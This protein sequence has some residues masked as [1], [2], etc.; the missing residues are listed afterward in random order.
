MQTAPV[1]APYP[2]GDGDG[3]WCAVCVDHEHA[4]DALVLV[5]PV[6]L[7]TR[8][9]DPQR[10]PLELPF[11][12]LYAHSACLAAT[13]AVAFVPQF[14]LDYVRLARILSSDQIDRAA[15]TFHDQGLYS[16]SAAL[17]DLLLPRLDDA[18]RKWAKSQVLERKIASLAGVRNLRR[19]NALGDAFVKRHADELG[20]LLHVANWHANF[21]FR[22]RAD[23]LLRYIEEQRRG[24]PLQVR[25]ATESHYRMRAAQIRRSGAA[26]SQAIR[27][28]RDDPYM[29]NTAYVLAGHIYAP[30]RPHRARTY[31]EAIVAQGSN[32]S[33]LYRAES[34]FGIALLMLREHDS[35]R[36]AYKLLVAAQYI[37]ATL[38]LQGTPH[39]DLHDSL[40]QDDLTPAT[41][42]HYDLQVAT[43]PTSERLGLRQ[44]AILHSGLQNQ[45]LSSL[46]LLF[47]YSQPWPDT[48]EAQRRSRVLVLGQDTSAIGTLR[49]I[50]DR[51]LERGYSGVLAKDQPD[52]PE[53]TNEGKI[54][55][56]AAISRFVVVEQSRAAGQIDE[57]QLL[58]PKRYVI[59]ILH[60]TGIQATWMQA[61][62]DIG[63]QFV[64]YFP[65]AR[66]ADAVERA[67]DWA[68]RKLAEKEQR[69]SGRY[70]WRSNERPA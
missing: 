4:R 22:R 11:G 1:I 36:E 67:C 8:A 3:V 45:L 59:A 65:Y 28:T 40:R 39:P 20:V 19:G 60:R 31:F 6:E 44:S 56:L 51:L 34:Y 12:D 58:A 35:L 57:L 66:I 25:D 5:V 49:E 68:E 52:V 37:Y 50:V 27:A 47:Q 64:E 41:I 14:I 26:A 32:V 15:K 30:E 18:G 48:L 55:R 23:T 38:R 16:V 17:K 10:R 13:P 9:S 7:Q 70:P 63:F 24:A 33:W 53:E 46:L 42:I 2:L 61:D 29:T 43:I 69:L 62:Y 21:G 54:L